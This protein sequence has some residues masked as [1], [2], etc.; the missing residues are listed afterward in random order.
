VHV[1][2]SHP[3]VDVLTIGHATHVGPEVHVRQKEDLLIGGDGIDDLDGVPGSTAVITFRFDLGRG[4]H[5]R[6]DDGARM[7]GLPCTELSGVD[8]RGEGTAGSEVG[9]QDGL[10]RRENGGRLGH[11][12]N[13]AEDDD[14]RR[15]PGRL[16]GEAERVTDEIGDVLHLGPFVVM[17]ENHGPALP[18]ELLDLRLQFSDELV[19][20]G[21]G[22]RS[23]GHVAECNSQGEPGKNC[24]EL[25][26]SR[27]AASRHLPFR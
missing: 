16:T 8:G 22:R 3:Y 10:G 7:L 5:V 21:K 18:R 14:V 23:T 17:G 1:T 25:Q 20:V 12:M 2:L 4:V 11:E 26:G 27:A 15:S 9:Q 13:A 24:E 6:D 19:P